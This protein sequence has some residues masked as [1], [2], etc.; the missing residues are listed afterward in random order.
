MKNK[1]DQEVSIPSLWKN[2]ESYYMQGHLTVDELL[3]AIVDNYDIIDSDD[4]KGTAKHWARLTPLKFVVEDGERKVEMKLTIYDEAQR[5][6]FPVTK[7]ILEE[8]S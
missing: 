4:I 3:K 5:G 1:I 6:R 2:N 8:K 7:I